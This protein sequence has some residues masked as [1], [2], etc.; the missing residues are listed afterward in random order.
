MM[1]QAAKYSAGFVGGVIYHTNS[2]ELAAY[3]TRAFNAAGITNV[4]FLITPGM[5]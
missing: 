2:P 3:Y 1:D 5:R 4:R